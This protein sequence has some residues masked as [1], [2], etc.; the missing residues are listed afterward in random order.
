MDCPLPDGPTTFWFGANGGTPSSARQSPA[1]TQGHPYRRDQWQGVYNCFFEKDAG[2]A[3]PES[4]GV[5]LALSHS[6]YGSD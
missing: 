3:K 5:Q 2:R 4:W 1:Q 6:L